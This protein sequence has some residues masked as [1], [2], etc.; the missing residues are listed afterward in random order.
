MHA[1]WMSSFR[2]PV[3]G[4]YGVVY[5]EGRIRKGGYGVVYT[6]GRIRKGGFRGTVRGMAIVDFG[7]QVLLTSNYNSYLM[8][9]N[10]YYWGG[11]GG[12]VVLYNVLSRNVIVITQK[13]NQIARLIYCFSLK[14]KNS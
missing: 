13:C 14:F 6:E 5:T 7:R 3:L 2:V 8:S 1:W 4:G 10:M 12:G 11:G 9:A